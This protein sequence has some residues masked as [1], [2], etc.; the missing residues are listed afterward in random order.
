ML[1]PE[2]QGDIVEWINIE[3]LF[4]FRKYILSVSKS[5]GSIS[6]AVEQESTLYLVEEW[7]N[8]MGLHTAHVDRKKWWW[9]KKGRA[10]VYSI[11][12]T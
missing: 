9:R 5:E 4:P 7:M 8:G 6:G 2:Y 3:G 10:L 11:E 12:S 1:K